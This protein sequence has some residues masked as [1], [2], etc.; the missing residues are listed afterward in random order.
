MT[1]VAIKFK[2]LGPNAPDLDIRSEQVYMVYMHRTLP[3]GTKI[4]LLELD[5]KNLGSL[6]SFY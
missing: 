5:L 6:A 3:R 4:A 2:L 1:C